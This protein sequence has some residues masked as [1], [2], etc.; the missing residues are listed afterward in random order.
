MSEPGN[1]QPELAQDHG[2]A[3]YAPIVPIIGAYTQ[4]KNNYELC[5]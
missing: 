4:K 5:Y 2:Q 3:E 1:D